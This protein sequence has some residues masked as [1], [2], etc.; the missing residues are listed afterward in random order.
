[1]SRS[2]AMYAIHMSAS[3][4]HFLHATSY[5]RSTRFS[6]VTLSS[7]IAFSSHCR[8]SF[9]SASS[10]GITTSFASALRLTSLSCPH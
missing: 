3:S 5:R 1:M 9:H 4:A 2:N 10:I 7:S 8:H 6:P